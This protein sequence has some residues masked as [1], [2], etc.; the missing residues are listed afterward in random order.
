MLKTREEE[1]GY[2]ELELKVRT[3]TGT[4][5]PGG[6]LPAGGTS[7]RK[8]PQSA[9]RLQKKKSTRRKKLKMYFG[10]ATREK[11]L[12]SQSG[13]SFLYSEATF[14]FSLIKKSEVQYV[15]GGVGYACSL[16]WRASF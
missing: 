9:P 6:I 7:H 10:G 1:R 12:D 4:P 3:T 8:D 16:Q 5:G 15:G 2:S 13:D 11:N 14:K